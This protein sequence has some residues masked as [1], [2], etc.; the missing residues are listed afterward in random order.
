MGRN[1]LENYIMTPPKEL[2][3]AFF[4]SE[5]ETGRG[6]VLKAKTKDGEIF[7]LGFMKTSK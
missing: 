6:E 3:G 4:Y 5:E 7:T 2:K 1:P